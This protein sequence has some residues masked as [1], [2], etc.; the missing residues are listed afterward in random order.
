MQQQDDI[1][2]VAPSSGD[3]APSIA[4]SVA[5][6]GA[7]TFEADPT[8]TLM[9]TVM[10]FRVAVI[11]VLVIVGLVSAFPLRQVFTTPDTFASTISVL[12][13]KKNNVT[14][15]VAATTAASVTITFAGP[16]DAGT[17]LADKLMD[18]SSNLML[19]LGVLYLEKYLLTVFGFVAF[20]ILIPLAMGMLVIAA[21]MYYRSNA[22]GAIARLA[23]K[24]IVLGAVLFATVPA[25]VA[26]T[27]MI[28]RT[29]DV[30]YAVEAEVDEPAQ[31]GEGDG[32]GT[33]LD[34]ILSI[35]ENVANA[36]TDVIDG[37]LGQVNRL[38]EGVAIML[39]TSCVIPILVLL[40][41]LWM[42]NLLLGINIDAPT[43]ALAARAQR[44]KVNRG[45]I[46]SAKKA[47]SAWR[48]DRG[49]KTQG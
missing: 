11:A 39:V 17:P 33:P 47:L 10:R 34:F 48:A 19:V 7:I 23:L 21:L 30:S 38:I 2:R 45:D 15:M 3:G 28:D 40:F 12:D 31:E 43:R 44:M 32:E 22:S 42:A 35:P 20:G 36:A 49:S 16:D 24:L 6:A 18:L 14:A 8:P 13:E 25:G 29:Y 9:D 26:V 37:L 1:E 41:F 5:D 27:D 46:R 4:V